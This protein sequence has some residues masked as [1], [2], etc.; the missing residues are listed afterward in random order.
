[1]RQAK[2]SNLPLDWENLAKEIEGLGKPDRR[3]LRS[4][5]TR[6]LRH[7]LKRL[8]RGGTARQLAAND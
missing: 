5:I 2:R 4:Q 8:P 7:L 6:I 3:E 1:L